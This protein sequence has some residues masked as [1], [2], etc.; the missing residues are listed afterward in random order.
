[1]VRLSMLLTLRVGG[2]DV[3]QNLPRAW[4]HELN[5]SLASSSDVSRGHRR[6]MAKLPSCSS[7]EK[8]RFDAFAGCECLPS[9]VRVGVFALM[10]SRHGAQNQYL[11]SST[12]P[13]IFGCRD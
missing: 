7:R 6:C 9:C 1:M 11:P 3:H 4:V 13:L 12:S 10:L 5:P 2:T 8:G